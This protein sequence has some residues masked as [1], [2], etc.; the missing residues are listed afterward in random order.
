MLTAASR[1]SPPPWGCE[2]Q[3][4]P[5]HWADSSRRQKDVV[6]LRKNGLLPGEPA[7]VPA[8]HHRQRLGCQRANLRQ[9]L[10]RR[11][12]I[13]E[14]TL[15]LVGGDVLGRKELKDGIRGMFPPVHDD[16]GDAEHDLTEKAGQR[17][18]VTCDEGNSVCAGR[19]LITRPA[20]ATI[21]LTC[22]ATVAI[23]EA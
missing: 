17:Q 16:E 20:L 11:G 7:R 4:Y 2:I 3:A 9:R 14:I 1:S 6:D 12:A 19:M 10:R 23:V 21:A 13:E 22:I 5:V 8:S 18:Q 15:H